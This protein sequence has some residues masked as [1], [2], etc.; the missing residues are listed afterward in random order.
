V[1]TLGPH[2]PD[3]PL[4]ASRY[5]GAPDLP[6]TASWPR[7]AGDGRAL[8]FLMQVD[9]AAV[10]PVAGGVLPARGWLYAFV[11]DHDGACRVLHHD[12]PAAAL[13]RTPAPPWPEWVDWLDIYRHQGP[14]QPEPL[15]PH[16]L[17]AAAG[18]DLPGYDSP[19]LDEVERLCDR[20]GLP[21]AADRFFDL[22]HEL[23][24]GERRPPGL[25]PGDGRLAA[26]LLGC[27]SHVDGDVREEAHLVASGQRRWRATGRGAAPTRR[28][29]AGRRPRGACCGVSSRRTRPAPASATTAAP[30]S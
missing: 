12:G 24:L 6:A 22:A 2:A 17:R 29:C 5:G 27:P 21:S 23:L 11:E 14:E 15:R 28:S 9:L 8:V 3:A 20:P 26:V 16:L 30:T 19:L 18:I 7:R 25:A 13:R 1:L 4:G 10:P